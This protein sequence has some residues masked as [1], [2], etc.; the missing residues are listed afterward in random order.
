MG[1][2]LHVA[3]DFGMWPVAVPKIIGVADGFLS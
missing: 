3:G 2:V 1:I